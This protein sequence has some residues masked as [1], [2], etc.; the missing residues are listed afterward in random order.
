MKCSPRTVIF[1]GSV[2]GCEAGGS[3]CMDDQLKFGL[4]AADVDEGVV[5][6]QS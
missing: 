3:Q 4:L 5:A 6:L 1:H 2:V